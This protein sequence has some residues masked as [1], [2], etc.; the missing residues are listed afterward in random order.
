MVSIVS[1][2]RAECT[3]KGK[4]TD[5]GEELKYVCEGLVRLAFDKLSLLGPESLPVTS[6]VSVP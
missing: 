1:D 2:S 4:D 3:I 6:A 5:C